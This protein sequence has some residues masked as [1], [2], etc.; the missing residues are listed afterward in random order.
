MP[1]VISREVRMS[2]I[3]G[4]GGRP[5]VPMHACSF[6]VSTFNDRG[7]ASRPTRVVFVVNLATGWLRLRREARVSLSDRSMAT[8]RTTDGDVPRW[9]RMTASSAASPAGTSAHP[10]TQLWKSFTATV[11]LCS[12]SQCKCVRSVLQVR[13]AR[14][15]EHETDSIHNERRERS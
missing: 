15:H 5:I 11:A 8:R 3:L 9:A 1:A 6:Q 13:R 7:F 4:E 2:F 12:Q 14:M 10:G